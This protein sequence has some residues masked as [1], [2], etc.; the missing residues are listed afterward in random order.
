M[1]V[2]VDN[3]KM[4][5]RGMIMSHMMADELE[6]LHEMAAKLGLK[7]SWFQDKSIP[8]YDLSEGKR[9][10]A[11]KLGAIEE[12]AFSEAMSAF[13]REWR[14]RYRNMVTIWNI[15]D[16][17]TPADAVLVDRT[18]PYGN[19]FIIGRDGNRFE[20]IEKYMQWIWRKQ[21]LQLR[22]M[23]RENLA[24]K[25]LV[26]HCHPLPCHASIVAEVSNGKVRP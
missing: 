20:V 4:P 8:H 3:M 22:M 24:G 5:W 19:P 7:R 14:R 23:M 12:D 13:R 2:Y 6:E 16:S 26:C 9:Q 25:D 17:R 18:T 21:Q 15:K 10:Q 1:A 11:I